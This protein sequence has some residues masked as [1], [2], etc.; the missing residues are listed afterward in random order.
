MVTEHQLDRYLYDIFKFY[1]K[2]GQELLDVIID[3]NSNDTSHIITYEYELGL[4]MRKREFLIKSS[5]EVHQDFQYIYGADQRLKQITRNGKNFELYKYNENGQV[6]SIHLGENLEIADSYKFTYDSNGRIVSQSLMSGLVGDSPL[7]IWNYVYD[8]QGM[9]LAKQVPDKPT[10]EFKD[11]FVYKY[12]NTNKLVEIEE[13]YPEYNFS[14][15]KRT[16]FT[17]QLEDAN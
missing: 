1:S 16:V 2:E 5:S 11:M 14:L 8:N 13:L 17:Y 3:S 4:L 10:N 9:L 7:R 12:D 15:W 6:E